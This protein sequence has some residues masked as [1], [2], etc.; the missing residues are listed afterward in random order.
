VAVFF[1]NQVPG[2]AIAFFVFEFPLPRAERRSTNAIKKVQREK[3]LLCLAAGGAGGHG[4]AKL[5]RWCPGPKKNGGIFR[6]LSFLFFYCFLA[7]RANLCER[8]PC[9]SSLH[10][11]VERTSYK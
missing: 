6:P 9:E 1:L 11:D 3:A 4:F 2:D 8:Q 7:Q 5:E 10:Q